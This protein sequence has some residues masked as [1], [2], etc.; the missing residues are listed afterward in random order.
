MWKFE[1]MNT[2]FDL[3]V[4]ITCEWIRP[5]VYSRQGCF[6]TYCGAYL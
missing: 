1:I 3:G 6:C 5:I 4:C 2:E